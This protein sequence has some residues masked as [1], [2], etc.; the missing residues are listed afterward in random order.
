[1]TATEYDTA[2]RQA[3][4]KLDATR[5]LMND[6]RGA[7]D[8]GEDYGADDAEEYG[9]LVDMEIEYTGELEMLKGLRDRAA[10]KAA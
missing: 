8:K 9:V 1:M 10:G 3:Q 7:W 5:R 6:M 2:I 4:G